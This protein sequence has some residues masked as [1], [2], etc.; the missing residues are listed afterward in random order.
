M[1]ELVKDWKKIE[2]GAIENMAESAA[3]FEK[4]CTKLVEDGRTMASNLKKI[5]DTQ[6]TNY[7]ALQDQKKQ[8]REDSMLS[9]EQ[10]TELIGYYNSLEEFD[11]QTF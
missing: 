4:I 10:K 8:I 9:E 6:K 5:M 2:D 11:K 7:Q 3:K 1:D